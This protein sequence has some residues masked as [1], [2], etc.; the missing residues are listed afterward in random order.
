M[1]L[2]KIPVFLGLLFLASCSSN[3]SKNTGELGNLFKTNLER[4][5]FILF[6]GQI[7]NSESDKPLSNCTVYLE[8]TTYKDTTSKEGKFNFN[9][10]PA[11]N[12]TLMIISNNFQ[13]KICFEIN[14][15]HFMIHLI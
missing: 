9:S 2:I 8:G 15:L 4:Q 11:G 10:I 14:G 1:R 12:Y 3:I 7:I 5:P 6:S 13:V